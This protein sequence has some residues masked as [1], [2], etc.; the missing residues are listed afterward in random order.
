M[1]L[2]PLAASWVNRAIE[3]S[4]WRLQEVKHE[5]VDS[6][7]LGRDVGRYRRLG[8]IVSLL[9]WL[10]PSRYRLLVELAQRWRNGSWTPSRPALPPKAPR[11]WLRW[12][13]RS[14]QPRH[15]LHPNDSPIQ[16]PI[17]RANAQS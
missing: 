5:D 9:L 14:N 12:V 16:P 3:G 17:H 10:L 2:T 6:D 11:S 15:L 7:G 8:L 4:G 1:R 13:F